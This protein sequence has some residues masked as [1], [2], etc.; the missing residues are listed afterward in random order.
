MPA[1]LRAQ[2]QT[3]PAF[4]CGAGKA[5]L[6][7]KDVTDAYELDLR[8]GT[9]TQKTSGGIVLSDGTKGGK[10]NVFGFNQRDNYI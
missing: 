9:L 4:T 10:Y 7:Q 5:Y 6:F 2:T 1:E 8:T 3:P